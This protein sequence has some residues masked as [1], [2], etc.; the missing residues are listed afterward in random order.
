VRAKPKDVVLTARIDPAVPKRLVGDRGRFRQVL[1]NL[2]GNAIKFTDAGTVAVE[3]TPAPG[4]PRD[5]RARLRVTVTDTGI[6]IPREKLEQIFSPFTQAD[7]HTQQQYG[8]TG[9]GLAISRQLVELMGGEIGVQSTVGE[10]AT[11]HFTCDCGLGRAAEMLPRVLL[12]DDTP[13]N[14]D[15]MSRVLSRLG[16]DGIAASSG[17]EA[18]ARFADQG[19]FGLVLLDIQMPEMDGFETARAIRAA[20][21]ADARVPIVA[22]SAYLEDVGRE[23]AEAAGME[24]FLS[25]PTR[26]DEVQRLLRRYFPSIEETAPPRPEAARSPVSPMPEDRGSVLVVDDTPENLDYMSRV[27]EQLQLRARVV[28]SGEDAVASCAGDAAFDLI[29]CDLRMPGMNGYQTLDALRRSGVRT[30]V[31]AVTAE[32]PDGPEGVRALRAGFDGFLTKP[33]R[34]DDIRGVIERFVPDRETQLKAA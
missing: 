34:V 32:S 20:E 3:V 15:F 4:V 23:E 1:I 8:G 30:P 11:F 26:V 33:C 10:G 24:E 16:L 6:G 14:L 29:L 31:V 17:R 12:V 7:A 2:I 22:W 21:D 25:K 27:L 18:L 9:L 28:N 19:P 13:E 5:G